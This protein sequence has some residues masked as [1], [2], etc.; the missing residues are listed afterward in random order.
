MAYVEF[1]I[2][3][4]YVGL[5]ANTPGLEGG[6]KGYAAPVIIVRVTLNRDYIL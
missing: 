3:E 1:V 4:P 2:E 5:D 6:I